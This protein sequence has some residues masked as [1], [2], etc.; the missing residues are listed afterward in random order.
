MPLDS[1]TVCVDA[2]DEGI[3]QLQSGGINRFDFVGIQS[4]IDASVCGSGQ[5]SFQFADHGDIQ[6][7]TERDP[8]GF[9]RRSSR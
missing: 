6:V 5:F 4:D 1:V 2:L 9:I 3:Q 7:F 8:A